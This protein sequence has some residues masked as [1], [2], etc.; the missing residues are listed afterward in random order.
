[1][2]ET[3]ALVVDLL[4]RTTHL[5]QAGGHSVGHQTHPAVHEVLNEH[6]VQLLG[7]HQEL[8]NQLA[9]RVGHLNPVDFGFGVRIT[10][11]IVKH[12]LIAVAVVAMA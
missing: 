8:L 3:D 9:F 12:W 2:L 4:S 11:P 10:P 1:V 5:T 7:R 6:E